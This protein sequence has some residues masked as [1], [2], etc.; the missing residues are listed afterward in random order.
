MFDKHQKTHEILSTETIGL[1]PA[2]EKKPVAISGEVTLKFT[3]P[4]EVY[5]NGKAYLGQEITVGNM[6]LA[7]EI[8][9]ICR[10]AYG[11]GILL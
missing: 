2:A 8:V 5:I 7:S 11:T 6:S 4:V 10:E 3:K 1:E 9:R